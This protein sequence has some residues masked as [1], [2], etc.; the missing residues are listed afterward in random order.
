MTAR[1][2]VKKIMRIEIR[3]D[4]VVIE[5]YV[6]AVARDSR[7]MKDKK[8]GKRFVEQV[9]PGVFKRALEHNEVQLLLNHDPTRCLGSTKTNLELYEDSIG[10]HARAEVTDPEVMEKAR[11]KK[12]RGWSFGFCEH[13]ASKEDITEVM[14]RRFVEEMKLVEVSIIDERKRPCYEGTSV[15][16]R[17]EGDQVLTPDP[18]EVRAVYIE[19]AAQKESIDLKKYK[20]RIKELDKETGK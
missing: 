10:L 14:E 12:L 3:A 6:N 18:M 8:T 16:V 17:A 19:S 15:E 13:D 2:K 11:E 4:S 20:N 7:P 5:G 1:K 9:T